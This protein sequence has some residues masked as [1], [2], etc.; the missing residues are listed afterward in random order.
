MTNNIV[1]RMYEHKYK[2]LDGFT[3][4]YNINKLVFCEEFVD[5][6]SAIAMEKKLKGWVRSKKLELIKNINP[7]FED[8]SKDWY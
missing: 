4:R 5:P 7:K 2:L 6:T 8:L 1:R 3:K